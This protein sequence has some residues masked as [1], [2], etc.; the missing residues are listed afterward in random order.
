MT[1]QA[2]PRRPFFNPWRVAG[3][4]LIAAL[5]SLPAILRFPWTASDFVIMG[6]LLGSV[7][8]GI[9]FLAARAGNIFV[10]LG[11][12][13]T[14]LTAFLTIWV[15]L[16]VGMIG[17]D[18]AYNLLFLA[19]VAVGIA[20]LVVVRLDGRR[21][22]VVTVAAAALQVAIGLGGY[23]QD[24]RGAILSA[25][26]GLFWLFAAALFRAGASR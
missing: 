22:A 23:G 25:T 6:V 20:G 18:N 10:R 2:M 24:P 4:G 15:N 26:F 7:G 14:V 13:V 19:P 16:A 8:L 1:D 21:S 12:V 17:D 5:L 3:W 11:A 9:E